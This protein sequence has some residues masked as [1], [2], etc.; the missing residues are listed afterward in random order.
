MPSMFMLVGG[1]ELVS[2]SADMGSVHHHG[3][4]Q[5]DS[6]YLGLVYHV[7]IISCCVYV[8]YCRRGTDPI[9]QYVIGIGIVIR[10]M[11][12]RQLIGTIG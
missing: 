5:N 12:E 2:I 4:V 6:V 9:G 1:E 11:G 10:Q 8:C 3:E 7:V